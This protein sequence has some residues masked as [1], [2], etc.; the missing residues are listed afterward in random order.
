MNEHVRVCRDCG[1][2]YRPGIVRCADCGGELED[3]YPGDEP[4]PAAANDA[5][6]EAELAGYRVLFTTAR[7]TD[8]VPMADRLREAA[9]EH[10]LAEQPGAAKEAPP[11]YAILV[12]DG[13]GGAALAA[14]TDLIAPHEDAASV[15]A[16]ETH[17]DP[18]KG[19]VRCPACGTAP[20]PDAS[21]CPEC[22]LGLG[23]G[24]AAEEPHE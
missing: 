4:R 19:Y 8:L 16:V 1:E 22:G 14:L 18:E 15:H 13:A 24:E 11:R 9:I 2:E 23:G 17:F 20:P 5:P 12:P 10:R 3:R 21:E 7:A 6:L